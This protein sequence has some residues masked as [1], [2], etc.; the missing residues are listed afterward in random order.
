METKEIRLIYKGRCNLANG[1]IGHEYIQENTKNEFVFGNKLVK[2]GVGWTI[3]C[4]RTE[5]GVK[6]PYTPMYRIKDTDLIDTWFNN[7]KAI[8]DYERLK[9]D[10]NKDIKTKYDRV[11]AMIKEMKLD[12]PPQQR[13]IFLLRI[14]NDI[15]K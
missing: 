13:R 4:T 10:V 11:I 3:K 14:V 8:S 2:C 6:G 15:F 7:D 5:T 1:K 12:L 9:R